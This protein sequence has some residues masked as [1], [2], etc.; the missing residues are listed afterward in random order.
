MAIP[1]ALPLQAPITDEN[2]LATSENVKTEIETVRIQN[3]NTSISA[4]KD[5]TIWIGNTSDAASQVTTASQWRSSDTNYETGLIPYGGATPNPKQVFSSN[6]YV[7]LCFYGECRVFDHNLNFVG[8]VS[9]PSSICMT[10]SPDDT[11][12]YY[13]RTTRPYPLYKVKNGEKTLCNSPV[14]GNETPRLFTY[15]NGKL[16][17]FS[18]SSHLYY[19][20]DEGTTWIDCSGT[21]PGSW[22]S[23]VN[24]V[25]GDK[26]FA[27]DSSN[28]WVSSDFEN[29]TQCSTRLQ[30]IT[31][32]DTGFVGYL[33]E[34]PASNFYTSTDGI[35][36]T[37][38]G[39]S[40]PTVYFDGFTF[41]EG[42]YFAFGANSGEWA[43][44][45]SYSTDLKNWT[46]ITTAKGTASLYNVKAFNNILIYTYN[47]SSVLDFG[48]VT[49]GKIRLT[50]EEIPTTSSKIYKLGTKI[51]EET[52]SS[53]STDS[54]TLS[55]STILNG[56]EPGTISLTLEETQPEALSFIT[57]K[58]IYNSSQPVVPEGLKIFGYKNSSDRSH[59]INS[60]TLTNGTTVDYSDILC[61]AASGCLYQYREYI[62]GFAKTPYRSL[63]AIQGYSNGIYVSNSGYSYDGL[64]YTPFTEV[65]SFNGIVFA[66]SMFVGLDGNNPDSSIY[67]STNG[68]TWTKG[69]TFSAIWASGLA[70][71]NGTFVCGSATS[72]NNNLYYSTDLTTWHAV[73]TSYGYCDLVAA[74][75]NI[76]A[77]AQRESNGV[78]QYSSNGSSWTVY[79][80]GIGYLRSCK[81]IEDY[82]FVFGDSG[83]VYSSNGSWSKSFPISSAK[84]I[85]KLGTTYYATDS[86]AMYSSDSLF[87]T[88]TKV[89]DT[90][91]GSSTAVVL[92]NKV[93][94]SQQ[95]FDPSK[96]TKNVLEEIRYVTPSEMSA[97]VSSVDL[98]G[99]LK[100]STN[101][102]LNSIVVVSEG[103][104]VSQGGAVSQVAFGSNSVVLSGSGATAFGGYTKAQGNRATALG[105]G[106]KATA[107]SAIQ[108]GNGTNA[109]ANTFN[110]G[111]SDSVNVQLL[112][113]NGQIPAE[114]LTNVLGDIETLLA[115]L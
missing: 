66:N 99:Y 69:A 19:S 14:T 90:S 8:A 12:F 98:T 58:G 18:S 25:V 4:D 44:I 37:D 27:Y 51:S 101:T 63:N 31:Q 15:F 6:N 17:S 93:I 88:Y 108:I 75:S 91:V 106:A 70:H 50:K 97:A 67:T 60:G 16:I 26:F 45:L 73:S 30:Y 54:I 64:N 59:I 55:D 107:A 81:T 28:M 62:N 83:M 34:N 42:S 13:A 78:I 39:I 111:L 10:V 109:I 86:S 102:D 114:R 47:S 100:N 104:I 21:F 49:K 77:I 2:K 22:G 33:S 95:I 65:S 96:G 76:F 105:F 85:F 11:L 43:Y 46:P 53:I 29:W 48:Y 112:D 20:T 103:T 115:D 57:G 7:Y 89:A 113:A 94:F 32:T 24:K 61:D 74:N 40:T 79:K 41:F 52:I 35:T 110:V 5:L 38:T 56:P 3:T 72:A 80:P 87:G 84:N 23:N 71:K 1:F 68:K 92:D 82:I 36:W 9:H